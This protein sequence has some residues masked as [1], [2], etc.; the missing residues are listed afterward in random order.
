MRK[1][2]IAF[3]VLVVLLGAAVLI[4]PRLFNAEAQR[5]LITD[6]ME[7]A[8]QRKVKLGE[9][10]LTLTPPAL[11]IE[12]LEIA[13]GPGFG[14]TPFLT[15]E[16]VEVHVT[17]RPLLDGKLEVPS[18]VVSKPSVHLVRNAKGEWNFNTLGK[19][20]E[21]IKGKTPA[22]TQST[23]PG[24]IDI[25][26]IE[27][28]DGTIAF[29]DLSGKSKPVTL[30]RVNVKLTHLVVGQSVDYDVSMHFP[31]KGKGLLT[32]EGQAGPLLD[33]N[34]PITAKGKAK[35]EELD[36]ASVGPFIDQPG[37]AGLANLEANF[38]QEE[39][40]M[41]VE[42]TYSVTGLRLDPKG[43]P[44]QAPISGKYKM[45]Y[46]A[47]PD[48]LDVHD[49]T[50]SIGQSLF[51]MAGKMDLAKSVDNALKLE[52][53]NAQLTDA[54]KLL[55]AVNI[56]LPAGSQVAAGTLSGSTNLRGRFQPASGNA[57]INVA[58]ARLTGYNFA[59]Q[60]A[61]VAKLVGIPT[62]NDTQ[63][64][65][66]AATL[67]VDNGNIS[68]NDLQ[69]VMPGMTVSGGGS[70]SQAGNLDMKMTAALTGQT[71]S[72]NLMQKVLL[73]KAEVPFF[74]KG[75]TEHPVIVPDAAAMLK[76]Q[77]QGRTGNI[78]GVLGGLGGLFGKKKQ[79]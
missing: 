13:E 52:T 12:G 55:P 41:P 37:M 18:V 26:E 6:K 20:P 44:A 79:Q 78:G 73:G 23:G 60:L 1:V 2:L 16:N 21:A 33:P 76:Q 49:L 11:R 31:G 14:K 66:L 74:I 28:T 15:A 8:L 32:T 47:H 58:N 46:T 34:K 9:I 45:T 43:S 71:A 24:T 4:L 75:T 68:T 39:K 5:S 35:M 42:G 53:T 40:S 36:L 72:T 61:N 3:V 22:A 56:R 10:H 17:L 63:L 70:M 67:R 50:M 48:R 30:D 65:K 27:V 25:G 54:A 19:P 7:A 77:I 69:L 57:A 59:G 62:G 38:T 29:S 64:E 51:K